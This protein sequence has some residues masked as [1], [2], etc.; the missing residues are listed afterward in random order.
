LLELRG[1]R[2]AVNAEGVGEIGEGAAGLISG[3]EVVDLGGLEAALNR[4]SVGV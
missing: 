1:D 4:S 2:P 3:Y